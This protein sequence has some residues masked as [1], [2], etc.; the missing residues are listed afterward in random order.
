MRR[1]TLI[2]LG[3]VALALLAGSSAVAAVRAPGGFHLR[4]TNG[5]A[6]KVLAGPPRE[7]RPGTVLVFVSKRDEGVFYA[8]EAEVDEDSIEADLGTVGRIDVRYVPSGGTTR[9]GA[10]CAPKRKASFDTGYYVGTIELHGEEGYTEADGSRARGEVGGALSL[11]CSRSSSEGSGGHSP[12]ARLT[13][14]RGFSGGKVE[15]VA[16]TNSPTRPSR[17]EASVSETRGAL[18]ILRSV[19]AVGPAAAFSFDV[20]KGEAVLAPPPPFAG[21]AEFTRRG[22]GPGRLLGTLAI[23]FPSASGVRLAGPG[24]RAGMIRHVDNPSHPFRPAASF[25]AWPSTK[26]WPTGFARSSLRAPS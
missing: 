9:E 26:L 4:G 13:A 20:P 11:L 7:G 15:L 18:E 16:R 5:F 6:V 3:G 14:R 23:D 8:T 19:R 10:H 1:G 21:T 17:F 2:V 12:G 22:S 24:T 25:S